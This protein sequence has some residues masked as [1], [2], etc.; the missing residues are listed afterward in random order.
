MLIPNSG[1]SL[2]ADSVILAVG[3][4]ADLSFLP[5]GMTSENGL[6]SIDPWGRTTLRGFFAGGMRPRGRGMSPRRSLRERKR[7]WR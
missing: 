6:I 4:R 7:P 2:K 1:F 3:E 5:E